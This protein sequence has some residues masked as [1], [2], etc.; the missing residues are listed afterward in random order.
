METIKRVNR[1]N[2]RAKKMTIRSWVSHENSRRKLNAV[3]LVFY[4][5]IILIAAVKSYV[6]ILLVLPVV[7]LFHGFSNVAMILGRPEVHDS[8]EEISQYAESGPAW[9][10]RIISKIE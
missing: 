1:Y 5:L 2:N 6:P 4:G 8:D 7:G 9:F 10:K 3:Y